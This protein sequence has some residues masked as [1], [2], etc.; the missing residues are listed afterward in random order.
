MTL[1][2]KLKLGSLESM[3]KKLGGTRKMVRQL[4][5]DLATETVVLIDE[6]FAKSRD[7]R[8][9]RWKKVKRGGKPLILTG[10]MRGG[11]SAIWSQGGVRIDVAVPYFVYH[12]G[13]TRHIKRRAMLPIGG[14]L[15][16]W[17]KRYGAVANR[18]MQ[19]H[20]G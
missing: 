5:A 15:G 9:R 16:N 6:G 19:E 2:V 1:S 17:R 14:N 8:G 11:F 20:F 12:Q 4:G 3:R 13:G 10:K 18:A 7:P